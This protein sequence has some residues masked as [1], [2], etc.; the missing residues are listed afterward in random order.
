MASDYAKK[1]N[2]ELVEI[3]KSRGLPHTGKKAD[4]VARLQEDD[5][6][7]AAAPAITDDVID[8]EDDEVP[9]AGSAPAKPTVAAAPVEDNASKVE[10]TKA[11]EGQGANASQE[12][13]EGTVTGTTEPEPQPEEKPAPNYSIGLSVTDL[14]EEL[15]KRKARAEKFGITEESKAAIDEAERKLQRAKRFGAD[16]ETPNA[17]AI[18]RL[19]QALPERSRKR[20]RGEN[21]QASR[22]GKRRNFN[23]RNNQRHRGRGEN[24]NQGQNQVQGQ[25]RS[26]NGVANGWSEKEKAAMEARKKRFAA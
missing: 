15:K 18:S 19:D 11:E 13:S 1:T 21:D 24:R 8:W 5:T 23:G 2:A 9:A 12:G 26:A 16:N 7:K 10:D 17:T 22:G 4:M 20:G 14:E 25:K 3:L 6:K